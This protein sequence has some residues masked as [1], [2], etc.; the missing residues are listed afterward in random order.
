L[1]SRGDGETIAQ[2]FIAGDGVGKVFR[3]PVGA[4]EMNGPE[5]DPRCMAIVDD[6]VVRPGLNRLFFDLFPRDESRGYFRRS[7][8]DLGTLAEDYLWD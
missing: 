8:R 6:S 1:E 2:R 7:F 3:A 5:N 4:I